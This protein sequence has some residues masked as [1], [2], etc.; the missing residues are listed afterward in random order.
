M[1]KRIVMWDIEGESGEEREHHIRKLKAQF[2]P[3]CGQIPRYR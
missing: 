2:E 3:L 1:I